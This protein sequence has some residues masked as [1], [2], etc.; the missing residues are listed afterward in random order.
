[1]GRTPVGEQVE[2]QCV[3]VTA[4]AS[5]IGRAMV[6]AFLEAGAR[7]H[8]ADLPGH[9]ADLPD[10]VGFT[11]GDVSRPADVDRLFDDVS[12]SLGS[13]DVLCNNV[14]IAGPTGPIEEVDVDSW[15]E[16][17]AVNVRSMFLCCRR[18]VPL[19]RE[20][21]GGVI[22]NTSS[23]AGVVGF[24]LRSPYAASKWA[25]VGLGAT[26]AMELGEFGIRTNTLCPGSV[27]GAR[28]DRVIAAESEVT[29][30]GS[31]E[32]RGRYEDQVSMRTFVQGRDIAAMAVFLAS[33]AARYVNGQVIAVDGGLES[34][35]T[36][37]R[38]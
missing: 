2:G 38:T 37:F 26:L 13:V 33:P 17:M 9:G 7:V 14:G 8:V 32:V 30:V 10:G 20:A 35:R 36:T 25:V 24:P 27:G 11:G 1:M 19:M 23:T 34:L 29:G 12:A 18:V 16:T 3:V 21:G 28:M 6:D 4:G 31:G 22:L 15:D 5:G